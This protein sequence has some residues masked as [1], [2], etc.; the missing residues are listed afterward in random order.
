MKTFLGLILLVGFALAPVYAF[1]CAKITPEKIR[2]VE[3]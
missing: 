1:R 2:T 3:H